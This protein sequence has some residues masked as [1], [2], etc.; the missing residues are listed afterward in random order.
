M[1]VRFLGVGLIDLGPGDGAS[2]E[3]TGNDCTGWEDPSPETFANIRDWGFNVVRLA[4]SW[5]NIE[6]NPPTAIGHSLW[7]HWDWEYLYAV[8]RAVAQLTSQGVAVIIEMSQY[9]WSPAFDEGGCPGRGMPAWLYEGTDMT[10]VGQAK[11]GFF[12][13]R[14]GVQ[15]LYANVWRMVAQRYSANPMVV[16][17]DMMNEPYVAPGGGD[18]RDLNLEVLYQKV[19][20]AIRSVNPSVVLIFQDSQYRPNG[21]YALT[22]PPLFDNVVYE[23]HLYVTDWQPDGRTQVLAALR[24]ARTWGV[25]L[26][27]GEFNAFGY[28]A[29]GRKSD[30]EAANRNWQQETDTLLSYAREV[31]FGWTFWAYS[32]GNSLI[33][34]GT[35][36]PK[37]GLL[38]ALQRGF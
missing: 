36:R 15:D 28:G 2:A 34:N 29:N 12:A 18:P 16:G 14:D 38:P 8:D 20:S 21:R 27:M 24:R 19:G 6:P 7:H 26:Y 3:E 25:P 4:I 31:S 9:Q 33:E 13:N 35:G 37:Q 22:E 17:A 5:A 11:R 32:G 30:A 10:T 23:F 1:P